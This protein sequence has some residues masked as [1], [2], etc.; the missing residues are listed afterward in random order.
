MARVRTALDGLSVGDAFGERF[1][2]HPTMVEALVED[3]AE[4]KAPWTW[5]DDTAMALGLCE[6]L[7]EHGVVERDALARVF[8]RRYAHEPNR[9]YGGGAHGIL[10]AINMGLPW[11][12]AA[13]MAFGGQ[14]SMGNGAA[15]RVAPVGAYFAD[16]LG[17]VV[18]HARASAEPT[19]AHPDGQAGAIAAAVATALAWQMSAGRI[20]R[21]GAT[22]LGIATEH[23]PAGPTRNG[24]ENARTL[25]DRG[26]S[27]TLAVEALGS[28]ARV[29]SSD[30][31]PFALWCAAH[32]LDDFAECM[33]RT[34]SGLGDRDTTCAIAGGVVAM[35]APVPP[36]WLRAREPAAW[37]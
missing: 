26:A 28:G 13:G 36:A 8:G 11:E 22:L 7:D 20:P 34:V 29:I 4:P 17:A 12:D 23:T 31:V 27:V 33:W 21:D 30:T 15:M 19:H 14:G 32:H 18:A 16:D 37:R 3:R 6:V 5:T 10:R 35:T 1:F 2:V 9:G 25:L 24:L